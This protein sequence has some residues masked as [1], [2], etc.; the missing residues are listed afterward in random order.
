MM[1]FLIKTT[2][3][4]AAIMLLL[5]FGQGCNNRMATP[6]DLTPTTHLDSVSYIIGYDYG[7][8]IRDQQIN[9][10]AA[11]IYKGL[12]DALNHR[13]NYFSDSTKVRLIRIFQH[14]VDSM[15]Q[16]RFLKM[17][18]QNK[19]AGKIFME[20]NKSAE[21]VNTLPD[22]LQYKIL[23][24]GTGKRY[25]AVTD[26][27]TIHYRAMYTDRTTFDMSYETGPINIRV[28][29]LVKGL[30]EGIQLMHRGAIFEFYIP[31]QLGYGDQNYIDLI[32]GGTTTIYN[33]ELI[34][35][36]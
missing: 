1:S 15:E 7:K 3:T 4:L 17:V 22:G 30:Q 13:D 12:Y 32:P 6:D 16:M 20:K 33:I 14:E 2:K 25:P 8:G 31:P 19:A 10:D 36:Y 9:A 34:E 28:H 21:G 29:H 11:M 27:V 35:I 23:K 26:S 18:A 24:T 5:L